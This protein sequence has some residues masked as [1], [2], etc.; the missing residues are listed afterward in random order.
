MSTLPKKRFTPEEYLAIDRQAERKS[1]YFDGEIFMMAGA[2]AAY[3]L[4]VANLFAELGNQLEGHLHHG[5]A[6]LA[7]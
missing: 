5:F 6:A 2:S 4:I 3:N 7:A 1:E